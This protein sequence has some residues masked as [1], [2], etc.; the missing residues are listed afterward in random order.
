MRRT[1]TSGFTLVELMVTIAIVAILLALGLPSFQGSIRSN[2]IATANNEFLAT[3]ALARTE[4]IRSTSSAGVCAADA[5]GA[6]CVDAGQWDDG[7]LVW[8]NDDDDDDLDY[9]A[10]SDTLVRHVQAREGIVVTVDPSIAADDNTRIFFD[11]RGRAM[12]T[13][14]DAGR[15]IEIKPESCPEGQELVRTM[16][17]TAVGQVNTEKAACP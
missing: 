1:R 3:L 14:Y 7:W 10:G 2:R 12:D 11:N 8:T 9:E 17:L 4:A 16:T 5:D 6:A 15:E 13:S